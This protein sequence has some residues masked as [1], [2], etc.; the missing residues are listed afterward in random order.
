MR[1]TIDRLRDAVTAVAAI[2][3]ALIALTLV[4][5]RVTG[6]RIVTVLSGSMEPT[7]HTG[8]LLFVRPVDTA[9]IEAGDAIAYMVAD[10]VMV[11]HRVIEVVPA[12]DGTRQFRTQ[13][14]ANNVADEALVDSD[15]VVGTPVFSVPL[16]GYIVNYAQRPPGLYVTAAV[17]V[18]ILTAAFLPALRGRDEKETENE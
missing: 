6:G 2:L 11:T 1:T 17:V 12:D 14:D 8:S 7:Y 13:G 10:G 3:T 18:L 9:E 4:L 5:T 15:S 16:A